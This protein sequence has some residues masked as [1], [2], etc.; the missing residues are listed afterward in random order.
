MR[1]FE[2]F[3]WAQEANARGI[4]LTREGPS[5]RARPAAA[6]TSDDKA[7]LRAYRRDWTDL[8]HDQPDAITY[9]LHWCGWYH[10]TLTDTIYVMPEA[11]YPHAIPA[12]NLRSWWQSILAR[13]IHLSRGPCGS[14]ALAPGSVLEGV[15]V[16]AAAALAARREG[17][18]ER[19]RE[20]QDEA[21]DEAAAAPAR[22]VTA[23]SDAK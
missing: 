12:P 23:K 2:L 3:T 19:W 14:L 10:Y 9:A 7:H 18:L 16:V 4:T 21:Q 8:A 20:A 6:L 5:F 11:R 22:E 15:D 1:R 13:K 17:V